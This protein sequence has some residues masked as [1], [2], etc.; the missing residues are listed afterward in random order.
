MKT[1]KILSDVYPKKDPGHISIT[2][3]DYLRLGC[4]NDFELHFSS[5]NAQEENGAG[6]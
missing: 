1:N 5:E 4:G 3:P 6:M 2:G